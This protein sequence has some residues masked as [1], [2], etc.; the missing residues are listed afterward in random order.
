M[1]VGARDKDKNLD[2]GQVRRCDIYVQCT[3]VKSFIGE[4][5]IYF[6]F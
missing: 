3:L 4:K 1:E 6:F 5:K 2:I